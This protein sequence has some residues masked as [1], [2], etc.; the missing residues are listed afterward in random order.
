VAALDTR[1]AKPAAISRPASLHYPLLVTA[2]WCP[3]TVPATRFWRDAAASCGFALRVVDAEAEE[4]ASAIANTEAAGVPCAIAGPGRL[5]YGYQL[6]PAL[7]CAFLASTAKP[8]HVL[9]P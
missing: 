1:P 6:S 9:A 3:F 2:P 5:H 7:A 8:P 4:G